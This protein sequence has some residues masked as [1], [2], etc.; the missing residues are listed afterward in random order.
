[1]TVVLIMVPCL[2]Q[3]IQQVIGKAIIGLFLVQQRGGDVGI[4]STESSKSL[5]HTGSETEM[6]LT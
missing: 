5:V 3:C 2:L 4:S 6:G 1:M